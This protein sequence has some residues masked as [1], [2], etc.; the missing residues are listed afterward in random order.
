MKNHMKR[1]AEY[2]S[3]PTYVCHN[4]AGGTVEIC[5]ETNVVGVISF[6]GIGGVVFGARFP[7][8]NLSAVGVGGSMD[9]INSQMFKGIFESWPVFWTA[10]RTFSFCLAQA[11][12][13]S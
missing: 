10:I 1:W 4:V 11:N 6:W 8:L 5:W 13:R 7:H 12:R 9:T 3:H 2:L